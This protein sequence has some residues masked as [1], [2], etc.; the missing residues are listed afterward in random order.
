[1]RVFQH[2]DPAD[3][4]RVVREAIV[5]GQPRTHRPWRKILILVEGIYSMEGE[6]LR[7]PEIIA[8]KQK[9]NC[10]LY[11]DE[12]HS[13]GALGAT[14][15]GIVEYWG[16]DPA[17]VDILMGTFTKSFGSVGGYIAGSRQLIRYLRQTRRVIGSVSIRITLF[18]RSFG[19]RYAAAMAPA[20]A[21][22]ALA[23][24]RHIQT[25]EGKKRIDALRRNSNYF[26][27]RLVSTLCCKC[28]L[29]DVCQKVCR[30]LSSLRRS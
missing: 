21:Q 1:M 2:N 20:C 29:T 25:T 28:C 23:A 17:D 9:Y 24:L 5:Y 4:E 13:I 19:Q 8:I 16:C 27:E 12:A 11:V 10:Y 30:R 3:L 7:L 6:V 26:R 18:F 14:G 22:M 15:R